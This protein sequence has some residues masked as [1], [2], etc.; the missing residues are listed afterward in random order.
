MKRFE[1]QICGVRYKVQILKRRDPED[2]RAWAK[3]DYDSTQITLYEADTTSPERKLETLVHECL[4]AVL[5]ETHVRPLFG[6]RH[7][8]IVGRLAAPL[9]GM[10]RDNAATFRE[11]G[12]K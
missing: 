11:I 4:H 3:I 9:L 8:E 7:E 10:F 12:G 1:V 6:R 5:H 2:G